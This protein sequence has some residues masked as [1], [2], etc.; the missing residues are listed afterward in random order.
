MPPLIVAAAITGGAMIYSSREERKASE[1]A[2][3]K[4]AEMQ[5]RQLQYETEAGEHFE[6]LNLKQMEMQSQQHQIQLLTDLISKQD[7][8]QQIVTL[9]AARSYSPVDRINQALEEILTVRRYLVLF[10][11]HYLTLWCPRL[12]VLR[13]PGCSAS[14]RQRSE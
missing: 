9:P 3:K 5:A 14:L 2:S 6:E 4:A 12:L 7:Q 1:K 10:Q 11:H 13:E 8:P